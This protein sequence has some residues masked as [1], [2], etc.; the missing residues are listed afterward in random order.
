MFNNKGQYMK[1]YIKFILKKIIWICLHSVWLLPVNQKKIF[2]SSFY[3]R[4]YSCNP[5][6][7]YDYLVKSHLA[8]RYK[9]VWE[10]V[11]EKKHLLDESTIIVS[12]KIGKIIQ[13]MTA[14][15]VITNVEFPW[16]IPLRKKQILVQT[17]HGG[18]AYKKVGLAVQWGNIAHKEQKLNSK[19]ITYYLSSCRR[20][21]E[22]QS[23]SKSVP[24]EHFLK[25]G[26][27]RN[28]IFFS[29]HPEL[30]EKV[31]NSLKIQDLNTKLVLYAPTYRGKPTFNA[32]SDCADLT[33]NLDFNKLITALQNKFGGKWVCAYRSHYYNAKLQGKE[34][35]SVVNAT[36]YDDMQELLFVADVL[37]TDYS[38]S[39]WDFALTNKP[40]FLF[41]PDY[42]SYKCE[43][44]YYT[45]VEEWPA[46]LA[47]S[48]RELAQN[49]A[50]FDMN[51]HH[52]KCKKHLESLGA[53]EN[54]E[55]CETIWKFIGIK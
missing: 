33:E 11:P 43:R 26:M 53:Y 51:N 1:T 13:C 15:Y 7:L 34:P 18:G 6:Y 9:I 40:M 4:Q 36:N 54:A 48:N 35:D 41:A 14:K 52:Q 50:N 27:P 38:S 8:T 32:S 45:P 49:I 46:S 42:D 25:S 47:T 55:S 29:S 44:S 2:F 10:L 3:G 39:I 28:T 17:W 31:F 37:I 16:Y 12:G 19:Q 24:S 5:K 21:T 30:K 20:F 22:V 23:P